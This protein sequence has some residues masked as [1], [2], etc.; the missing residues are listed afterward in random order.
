MI[1]YRQNVNT[2]DQLDP[3]KLKNEIALALKKSAPWK[4]TDI[5]GI[6]SAVYKILPTAK[7]IL[8]DFNSKI[9][10]GEIKVSE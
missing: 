3:I 7:K 9:L 10:T 4:A 1:I 5:D 2:Q 8:L 6:P